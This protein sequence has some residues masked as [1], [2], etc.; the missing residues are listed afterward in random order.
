METEFKCKSTNCYTKVFHKLHRCECGNECVVPDVQ[1]D[2]SRILTSSFITKIRNKDAEYGH[3]SVKGELLATVVYTSENGVEKLEMSVPFDAEIQADDIDST[4]LINADIRLEAYDLRVVN[5]RKISLTATISM[6]VTAYKGDELVWYE[7][8]E[9]IPECLMTKV[10]STDILY[11]ATVSEKTFVVDEEFEI[12][13]GENAKLLTGSSEFIC[14]GFENVGEKLIVRGKGQ[15]KCLYCVGEK[16]RSAEFDVPFSQLFEVNSEKSTVNDI[17][18][19]STGEYYDISDGRLF[20]ELHGVIQLVSKETKHISYVADAFSCRGDLDIEYADLKATHRESDESFSDSLLLA[21]EAG[22]DVSEI[23]FV[24]SRIQRLEIRD[25]EIQVHVSADIVYETASGEI[26]SKKLHGSEQF[27]TSQ[28]ALTENASAVISDSR[29]SALGSKIE[30]RATVKLHAKSC[31]ADEIH[32][33]SKVTEGDGQV[34]PVS[35]VYLVRNDAD[36]W[37][38]A[39]KYK[40]DPRIIAELNELDEENKRGLIIVPVV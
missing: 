20:A 39:K 15:I 28:I 2:I 14:D 31:D 3:I 37:S 13:D 1:Q 25:K 6:D 36:I 30:F 8:A 40:S 12:A 35:A 19:F 23:L 32:M 24:N 34:T 29:A 11:A 5:P 33:I 10:E 9:D 4:S 26:I 17:S 18:F 22:E 7:L 27:D 21:Y 16:L 38:I